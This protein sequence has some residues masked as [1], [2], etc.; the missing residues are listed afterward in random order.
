MSSD[1]LPSASLWL[2]QSVD[3]DSTGTLCNE[4]TCAFRLPRPPRKRMI[5]APP[6]RPN[7]KKRE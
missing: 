2:P 5:L 7:R 4:N 3:E 1:R 6:K